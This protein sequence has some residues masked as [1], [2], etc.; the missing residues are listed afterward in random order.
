MVA[1]GV[2]AAAG[3]PMCILPGPGV[4]AIA[5][6]VAL[7]SRGQRTFSGRASTKLEERLDQAAHK[8]GVAAKQQAAKVARKAGR[9]A[10]HGLGTVARAGGRF[11]VRTV[12]RT[13]SKA[14]PDPSQS[15][16]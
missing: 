13:S 8:A 1:G 11:V 12:G 10:V 3:V 16:G 4:A 6:G 9:A 15:A 2:L 14:G 7:I 5:G